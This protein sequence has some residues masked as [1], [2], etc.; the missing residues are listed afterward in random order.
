MV[1]NIIF[2]SAAID[3]NGGIVGGVP[4]D[5]LD[6]EEVR[7]SAPYIDSR[8]WFCMRAKDKK[9]ADGIAEAMLEATDND[10][11]GYNQAPSAATSVYTMFHKYGRIAHIK[12]L[13]ATDCA[14]LVRVCVEQAASR[15]VP[16]FYTLTLQTVLANTGLFMPAFDVTSSTELYNGDILCTGSA[17]TPVK[18]HCCVVIGNAKTNRGEIGGGGTPENVGTVTGWRVNIRS[19][20]GMEGNPVTR[21]ARM[22]ERLAYTET[23]N[24]PG[25]SLPWYHVSDGW[26]S[27]VYFEP[28]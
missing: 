9:I 7:T 16:D 1:N 19:G 3:E 28:D 8:G 14:K 23:A 21:V 22:G 6:G 26:I 13:C 10:K 18:G 11:I 15:N 24:V 4:G 5:Q 12:E 2:G 20:A 17:A 27:G 25:Y